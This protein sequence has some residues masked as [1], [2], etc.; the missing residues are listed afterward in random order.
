MK[1]G[2]AN[3]IV[4]TALLS[5]LPAGA[6]PRLE[7]DR[8]DFDFATVYRGDEARHTF[9]LSNTGTDTLKITKVR[10]SCGCTVPSVAKRE[11]GPGE[12]TELT[13]VFDSGRFQGSVTKNI[14][15]YSNDP[16][17]PITKLTIHA[18]VKQDLMVSPASI[19]FAGLK[20]GES[21]HRE[22]EIRNLS[23]QAVNIRE[24]A[25]TV[26][27]LEIQLEKPVLEPDE[28]TLLHLRIPKLS[29]GM[30]LT[31]EL[32]IFNSSHEDELK[33]RLYGGLIQ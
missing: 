2:L 30:K 12:Q 31:G 1:V 5:G 13:A 11:L 18:Y 25:S 15:V 23:G 16:A 28:V 22:I 17:S 6:E 20:E 29:K 32:T 24:I 21:V 26:S 27:S 10:S 19:Y 14:Y 4:F 3:F 33:I 9:T 7:V 8:M